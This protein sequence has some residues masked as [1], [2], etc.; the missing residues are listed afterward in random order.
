MK[1][2]GHYAPI[3]SLFKIAYTISS[4][5]LQLIL[6][7]VS[8]SQVPFVGGKTHSKDAPRERCGRS[9]VYNAMFLARCCW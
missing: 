9:E 2:G 4:E 7:L 6:L 3:F 8:A 1:N 5:S